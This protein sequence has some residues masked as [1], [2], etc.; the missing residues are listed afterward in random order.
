MPTET[1]RAFIPLATRCRARC[2]PPARAGRAD[3]ENHL[4]RRIHH[5]GHCRTKKKSPSERGLKVVPEALEVS[6]PVLGPG[7]MAMPRPNQPGITS[8]GPRLWARGAEKPR[9]DTSDRGPGP[10]ASPHAATGGS[11]HGWWVEPS[12]V[13]DTCNAEVALMFPPPR[14]APALRAPLG[15]GALRPGPVCSR[16][17]GRRVAPVV[18]RG[19]GLPHRRRI[20]AEAAPVFLTP[21]DKRR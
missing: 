12:F 20:N 13:A 17:C 18:G 16:A 11:E 7:P 1:R 2:R 9:P 5:R 14:K 4:E 3:N 10:V 19:F 6:G 8:E 21:P 15:L